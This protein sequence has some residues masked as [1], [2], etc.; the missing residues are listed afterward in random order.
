MYYSA[1]IQL[2]S[3]YLVDQRVAQH[4]PH[5][6]FKVIFC[7]ILIRIRNGR[8][9]FSH[10]KTFM[11]LVSLYFLM[12]RQWIRISNIKFYYSETTKMPGQVKAYELQSKCAW[13]TLIGCGKY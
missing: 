5:D 12:Q 8:N 9:A 4:I 7:P 13:M 6:P 2:K 1:A 10:F 11:H 3:V